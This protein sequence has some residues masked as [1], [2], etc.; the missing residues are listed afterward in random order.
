MAEPKYQP[1]GAQSAAPAFALPQVA[2][3]GI[4]LAALLAV[5]HAIVD[6]YSGFLAPLLPAL[7]Q[8][9]DLS[10]T[11]AS[12]LASVLSL[13]TSFVQPVFGVLADRLDRRVF[14]IAGPALTAVFLSLIGLAPSF[15]ILLPLLALGGLGVAAFHPCA[16]SLASTSAQGRSRAVWLSVFSAGGTFGYAMGPLAVTALVAATDLSLTWIAMI[17]GLVLLAIL[18]RHLPAGGGGQKRGGRELA[19][20]LRRL[21]N[22]VAIVVLRALTFTSFST[23]LPVIL[24]QRNLPLTAGGRAVAVYGVAGA[25]GGIAGSYLAGRLGKKT[26]VILSLLLAPG[27]LYLALHAQGFWLLPAIALAGAVVNSSLPV[28]ILM[29]QEMVPDQVATASSLTMGFGWGIAGVLLV[30]VGRLA[31]AIGPQQ[32]LAVTLFLPFISLW[33]ALRLTERRI[34]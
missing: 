3:S 27:V 13:S 5:A 11:L 23:F 24:A 6:S 15:W 29:A 26:I 14:L 1:V 8:R 33:F 4:P 31:D 9:Y 10:L 7:I 25:L 16:A 17:P 21:A 34:R 28:T 12:T 20:P 2:T 32:A 22:P 30:L 18:W 19:V